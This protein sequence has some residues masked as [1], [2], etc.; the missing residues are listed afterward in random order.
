MGMFTLWVTAKSKVIAQMGNHYT[1]PFLLTFNCNNYHL[2]FPLTLLITGVVLSLECD[3][4]IQPDL[5]AAF[6]VFVFT[7]QYNVPIIASE[8]A[9]KLTWTLYTRG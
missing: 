7:I 2:W 4:T 1:V 6:F 5:F 9:G 3:D 8:N